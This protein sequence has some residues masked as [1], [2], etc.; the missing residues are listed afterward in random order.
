MLDGSRN[1]L[2]REEIMAE[3]EGHGPGFGAQGWRIALIDRAG[4]ERGSVSVDAYWVEQT[5]R[6][7]AAVFKQPREPY[8]GQDNGLTATTTP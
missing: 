5:A 4:H 1:D 7:I 6:L 3:D 8:D 2:A